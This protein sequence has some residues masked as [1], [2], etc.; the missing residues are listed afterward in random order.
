MATSRKSSLVLGARGF[1]QDAR[2]DRHG[3]KN[4]RDEQKSG[5]AESPC[6][7]LEA[8]FAG[9]AEDG[10]DDGHEDDRDIFDESDADHHAAVF[11]AHRAAIG[12]QPRKN[13]GAGDGNCC[14]DDEALNHRP[15]NEPGDA[16]R[17]RQ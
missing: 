15:A 9:A 1:A 3:E 13:H 5:F 11:G 4:E 6:G 14:A 17:E 16:E 10:N 7:F 2:D 12:E 8:A